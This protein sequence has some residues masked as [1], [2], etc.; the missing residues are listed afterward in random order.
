MPVPLGQLGESTAL[1]PTTPP[2]GT[3]GARAA[4][5]HAAL[6]TEVPLA[7]VGAPTPSP[8]SSADR[9]NRVTQALSTYAPEQRATVVEEI[10]RAYP[11]L[12]AYTKPTAHLSAKM[13][14]SR[15][16]TLS[17]EAQSVVQTITAS[18][19]PSGRIAPAEVQA[20]AQGVPYVPSRV[21]RKAHR[22]MAGAKPLPGAPYDVTTRAHEETRLRN[23]LELVREGLDGWDWYDKGGR[24]IMFHANEDPRFARQIAEALSATSSATD[25]LVNAGMGV[26][27]VQQARGGVPIRTGRY[28]QAMGK[29]VEGVF[30]DEE[31]ASGK[32]HTAFA[33]ALSRAGGFLSKHSP[34][35][36]VNDIWQAEAWGYM[37]PDGTPLRRGWTDAEHAWMDRMSDRALAAVRRD[38]ALAA[39]VPAEAG[40][41]DVSRLQAAAWVGGKRRAAKAAAAADALAGKTHS[42]ASQLGRVGDFAQGI[43]RTYAQGGRETMPGKTTMHMPELH[44]PAAAPLREA[45]HGAVREQSGIYDPQMRDQLTAGM[46]GMVG[47]SIE[48]PGMFKGA[49]APGIQTQVPAGSEAVAGLGREM[50]AGTRRIMRAAENTHALLTAQ[51]AAAGGMVLPADKGARRDGARFV[52]KSGKVDDQQ[53]LDVYRRITQAGGTADSVAQIFTPDGLVLYNIPT[54]YGGLPD[55]VFDTLVKDI[56][57]TYGTSGG[58]LHGRWS[59]FYDTNNWR[60][61]LGQFGQ[62]YYKQIEP[63]ASRFDVTAPPIAQNML[64][65][66]Q[67]LQ[68]LSGGKLTLSTDQ[69]YLR[70]TIANEGWAGLERLAKQFGVPVA[71]L[72]VALGLGTSAQ[73]GDQVAQ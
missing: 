28:P 15:A 49:T 61:N 8:V 66:D 2:A 58:L 27:G 41:W 59:G 5:Q 39:V 67:Q 17:P 42:G 38:P 25:V 21:V 43:E 60:T 72:A 64:A 31:F 36:P 68:R 40:G 32:K 10:A 22:G 71:L 37:N 55:A 20:L 11:V 53:M 3:L 24:S 19:D 29:K 23:Y 73:Q 52:F 69:A 56:Q 54:E 48:G 62:G 51:D 34:D 16:A 18:L 45:L 13:L 30:A 33:D 44:D 7:S 26:K 1:V 46:G 65:I 4:T 14:A 9:L 57:K 12:D 47:P 35:R 70:Q 6:T 50:D 63:F